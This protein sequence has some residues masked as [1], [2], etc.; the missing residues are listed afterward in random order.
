MPSSELTD[1]AVKLLDG[2]PMVGAV[3]ASLHHG[4]EGLHSVEV[5][6]FS[7]IL[8]DALPDY[9]VIVFLIVRVT[10]EVIQID[11]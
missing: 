11:V 7:D 10:L 5:R 1:V 3:I 4:P 8:A 2:H 6:Q 9:F